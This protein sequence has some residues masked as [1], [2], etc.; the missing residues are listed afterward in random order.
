M[1]PVRTQI[2]TAPFSTMSC[3]VYL[4]VTTPH[5]EFV[6]NIMSDWYVE[7]ANHSCGDYEH[8]VDEMA[9]AGLTPIPSVKVSEWGLMWACARAHSHTQTQVP[10]L[11]HAPKRCTSLH[12]LGRRPV[13]APRTRGCEFL[14]LAHTTQTHTGRTSGSHSTAVDAIWP[15]ST[16]VQLRVYSRKRPFGLDMLHVPFIPPTL[17]HTTNMSR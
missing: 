10:A 14:A 4:T 7:A 8:S 6:V 11:L 16:P 5:R 15:S 9:L 3:L 13:L 17:A 12:L 1:C 2:R